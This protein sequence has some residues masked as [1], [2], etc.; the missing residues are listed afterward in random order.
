MK[1]QQQMIE[2]AGELEQAAQAVGRAARK[3]QAAYRVVSRAAH[4]DV[5]KQMLLESTIGAAA[6]NRL[7]AQRL[8]ALGLGGVLEHGKDRGVVQDLSGVLASK[9]RQ[10]VPR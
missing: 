10:R 9:I 3:Y 7:I 8:R 6:L 5:N 4:P 1:E 2:A